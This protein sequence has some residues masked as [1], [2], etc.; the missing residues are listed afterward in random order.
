MK[1]FTLTKREIDIII[2]ALNGFIDDNILYQEQILPS[3]KK[4]D[5]ISINKLNQQAKELINKLDNENNNI[6][7]TNNNNK[8]QTKT[9]N[10]TSK[11]KTPKNKK[12]KQ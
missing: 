12:D 5:I 6:T 10:K 11:P 1:T 2:L 8:K 3:L 7:E 9:T 4:E